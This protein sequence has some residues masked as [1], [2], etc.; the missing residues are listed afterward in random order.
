M[1]NLFKR[2][3]AVQADIDAIEKGGKN[4]SQG[5]AFVRAADVASTVRKALLKQGVYCAT[6]VH[7]V[8]DPL[9]IERANKSPIIY[10]NVTGTMTF[11]NV[12]EPTERITV[13]ITGH[14]M[15]YGEDKGIYKAITGA[16]KYGLR[17]AFLIPDEKMDPEIDEVAPAAP[18]P[19]L[20]GQQPVP[21]PEAPKLASMATDKQKAM[22]RAEARKLATPLDGEAFRQFVAFVTGKHSSKDLEIGDIDA[23]L[24]KFK[25]AELV[26]EFAT[27]TYGEAASS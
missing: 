22:V 20:V 2:L 8:G 6:S 3:L 11:V 9:V 10:A 12:D 13:N 7:A 17:T 21:R 23:I 27:A 16:I 26:E 18:T 5:Y 15:A 25:N 1:E 24:L 14:G 19:L 4:E